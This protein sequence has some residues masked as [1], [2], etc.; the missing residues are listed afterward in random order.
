M[1]GLDLERVRS[2]ALAAAMVGW[3][4]VGM[5]TSSLHV[6]FA[7][8]K[9]TRSSFHMRTQGPVIVIQIDTVAGCRPSTVYNSRGPEDRDGACVMYALRKPGRT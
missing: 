8:R 3:P 2:A 4:A 9:S 7:V 1:G 5:T 6:M